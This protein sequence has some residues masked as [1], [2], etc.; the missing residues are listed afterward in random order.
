MST[1]CLVV[2]TPLLNNPNHAGPILPFASTASLP[3]AHS[4]TS[5][6]QVI[7]E[8][9]KPITGAEGVDMPRSPVLLCKT[10]LDKVHLS[11]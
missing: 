5:F 9:S 11:P 4:C 3:P 2:P 8:V 10:D 1:F 6:L 7:R